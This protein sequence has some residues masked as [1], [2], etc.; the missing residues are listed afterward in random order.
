MALCGALCAALPACEDEEK[1]RPNGQLCEAAGQ[2]VSNLCH[3]STCLDPAADDDGDGLINEIEFHLGTDAT[4]PDS[5]GDGIPDYTEVVDPGAPAD[6]DQDGK[7]DALESAHVDSDCN[8]LAD[9]YDDPDQI[10]LGEDD[11]TLTTP[12]PDELIAKFPELAESCC[13]D[14]DEDGVADILDCDPSDPAIKGEQSDP[15]PAADACFEYTCQPGFKCVAEAKCTS[16]EPCATATCDPEQG[17]VVVPADQNCDDGNECTVDACVNDKEC[18]HFEKICP[19]DGDACTTHTCEANNDGVLD[20]NDCV[21]P[22]N[23]LACECQKDEDCPSNQGPCFLPDLCEGG[24]CLVSETKFEGCCVSDEDCP[25][26]GE[27]C[28]AASNQCE[29]DVQPECESDSDCEAGDNSCV[30]GVCDDTGTCV[31]GPVDVGADCDDL[32]SCTDNDTCDADGLCAGAP[33]VCDDGNECTED[34]CDP[35]MGCATLE[36]EDGLSCDLENPCS[37]E[38]VC[39][40]GAC[41]LWTPVLCDDGNECTEDWCDPSMGCTTLESEDG[42]MCDLENPCSY[43]SVCLGGACELWMP[44][45]C[46]DGNPCTSDGAC[47][48][49]AGGCLYPV[50]TDLC[51][52][53]EVCGQLE[54]CNGACA[55]VNTV[56]LSSEMYLNKGFVEQDGGTWLCDKNEGD[57][58]VVN[59]LVMPTSKGSFVINQSAKFPQ[60]GSLRLKIFNEVECFTGEGLD[61]T[62]LYPVYQVLLT[63]EDGVA[64]ARVIKMVGFGE[65]CSMQTVTSVIGEPGAPELPGP[66]AWFTFSVGVDTG[67]DLDINLSDGEAWFHMEVDSPLDVQ[68]PYNFQPTVTDGAEISPLLLVPNTD[69]CCED[70]SD[71]SDGDPCTE[72]ICSAGACVAQSAGCDDGDPCTQ[73][74]CEALGCSFPVIDSGASLSEQEQGIADGCEDLG[75]TP[76]IGSSVEAVSP[77]CDLICGAIQNCEGGLGIDIGEEE[78]GDSGCL[79]ACQEDLSENLLSAGHWSCRAGLAEEEGLCGVEAEATIT[80][81]CGTA[82]CPPAASDT[83][84]GVCAE[85]EGCGFSGLSAAPANFEAVWGPGPL[86]ASSCTGFG[87]SGTPTPQVAECVSSVFQKVACDYETAGMCAATSPCWAACQDIFGNSE[88][89][90]VC[91]GGTPLRVQLGTYDECE[92]ACKAVPE[93]QRSRFLGCLHAGGCGEMPMQCTLPQASFGDVSLLCEDQCSA[94]IDACGPLPFLDTVGSCK[95]WCEGVSVASA[96][97]DESIDLAAALL[98]ADCPSGNERLRVL[99]SELIDIVPLCEDVCATQAATECYGGGADGGFD[100]LNCQVSC[101]SEYFAQ[102]TGFVDESSCGELIDGCNG[103]PCDCVQDCTSDFP[104]EV[105]CDSGCDVLVEAAVYGSY[106]SCFDACSDGGIGGLIHAACWATAPT[107]S[108]AAM[109][110]EQAY[111]PGE[112]SDP[113]V[114]LC[115]PTPESPS[116]ICSDVAGYTCAL[117][118]EGARRWAAPE[119]GSEMLECISGILDASCD[120]ASVGPQCGQLACPPYGCPDSDEP[121]TT[122]KCD[123]VLGLCMEVQKPDGVSCAQDNLCVFDAV[124]TGGVC[125]GSELVCSLGMGANGSCEDMACDP[126][127]GCI[128]VPA[129]AG[130]ACDDQDPCSVN[131]T[132]DDGGLCSGDLLTCD[133]GLA[134]TNDSCVLGTGCVFEAMDSACDDQVPCTVDTCGATGCNH[135]PDPSQCDDQNACTS[136]SCDPAAGCEYTPTDDMCDDGNECTTDSCDPSVGCVN[137]SIDF[138]M[139]IPGGGDNEILCQDGSTPFETEI[140][141]LSNPG[142]ESG[143]TDWSSADDALDFYSGTG[144]EVCQLPQPPQGQMAWILGDPCD[145][146]GGPDVIPSV[147]AFTELSLTQASKAIVQSGSGE[148]RLS[149]QAGSYVSTGVISAVVSVTD[150]NGDDHETLGSQSLLGPSAEDWTVIRAVVPIGPELSSLRVGVRITDNFAGASLGAWFDDVHV[151]VLKCP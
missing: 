23:P 133:D 37:S 69:S 148:I 147:D 11:N 124:C 50:S 10:D 136:E 38:S 34:W 115:V 57:D 49:E 72:H 86:C 36:S 117:V 129:Q 134:C 89:P 43:E 35:S 113:C 62:G 21:Y 93:N 13:A 30:P 40:G 74:V 98:A 119:S 84:V 28:N 120:I 63:M 60:N 137:T 114:E 83:C 76:V 149:V 1:P 54:G 142:A 22:F 95:S 48:S 151:E 51:G 31:E 68:G 78:G 145:G 97:L 44:V 70:D 90:S 29:P 107:A 59:E 2:C 150:E 75:C 82:S 26:P 7:I 96:G 33:K 58:C 101:S 143:L 19:D 20:D 128:S 24:T 47:D 64:D 52:F 109:R 87:L 56:E 112:P 80:G 18:V 15:C 131:D 139:G 12:C 65:S 79:A 55:A 126:T 73:D 4:T 6:Q 100:V 17:C 14:V 92:S 138:C 9:Q 3:S 39:V 66:G 46:E 53:E 85:L 88:S 42:A 135:A 140:V 106:E 45:V 71:C 99:F 121:C 146:Q 116:D 144:S 104:L 132:C 118:C 77:Y 103:S 130:T 32:D 122:G 61:Q 91:H 110:C 27:V 94:A 105:L 123:L 108:L 102:E 111:G 5:D 125:Q 8:N 41:E 16:D 127:I 67:G 25:E 81:T 141:V